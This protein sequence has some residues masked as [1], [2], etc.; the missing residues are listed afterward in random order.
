MTSRAT[1]FGFLS[2]APPTPCG[3]A[4]FTTAL[5]SALARQ[6][7]R[8]RVVRV[9]DDANAPMKGESKVVGHLVG[10]DPSTIE[11][12]VDALNR[13]DIAIVQHEYG[14][15]GGRDG[16]DVVTVLEGLRIPSVAI[17]H[18]ILP[19]PMSHQREVLDAVILAADAV[20]VM[21]D[22]AE[23]TLRRVNNVGPTPVSVIAHGAAIAHPHRGRGDGVHP[24][25]LTW[26]LL[27]PGKGVEWVIDA[28]MDLTDLNPAPRYVVAGCTHPKVL[29]YEG[30]VYRESLERRVRHNGVGAMVEFDNTYRS[31]SSLN[32]LIDSADVVVLPYDSTEQATSGVL[33]DAIA[34]GRPVVATAFPHAVELL[35]EGAGI[36]VPH[37]DP[38]ALSR[39]IRRLLTE[40]E[41]VAEMNATARRL[42]PGL[43]WDAIGAQYQDLTDRLLSPVGVG[44]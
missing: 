31:L 8:V 23:A 34:A 25:I 2:S 9:V 1:T 6:G 38:A 7:G 30:D 40:P 41:L 16:S 10:S 14:L 19:D 12:A 26:G 28:L 44:A 27:G 22:A 17:L 21:T 39:A 36:V 13:S 5:G 11:G 37:R 33:V 35:G 3:I 43:S 15:Y 20:V 29:A 4:T 24:K 32:T 42:A 18:T